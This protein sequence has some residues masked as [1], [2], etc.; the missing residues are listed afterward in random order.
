MYRISFSVL[1]IG[2]VILVSACSSGPP[3]PV[4]PDGSHRVPVNQV[5]PIPAASVPAALPA[6]PAEG[7]GR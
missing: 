5:S 7:G 1:S 2:F 3:K 6:G 4:L